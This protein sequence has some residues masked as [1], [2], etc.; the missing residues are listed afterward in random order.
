VISIPSEVMGEV[1]ASGTDG[2]VTQ[3]SPD[4]SRL[5]SVKPA[6]GHFSITV[7]PAHLALAGCS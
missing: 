4:G 2:P 6:G 7:Q 5:V 3:T 1:T